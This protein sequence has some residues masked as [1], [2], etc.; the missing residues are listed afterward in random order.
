[1]QKT[2]N[3]VLTV[4][5]IGLGIC[6]VVLWKKLTIAHEQTTSAQ[7]ALE[8]EK[9]VRA[10]HE[11]RAKDLE[12]SNRIL[13]DKVQQFTEVTTG[14]RATE[15]KQSSNLTAM[16]Q[17]MKS[18]PKTGEGGSADAGGFGK[19]M[20]EM[21]EKM[22]KDPS[23]REMV[24]GQQKE[25]IK[26]MYKGLF[27]ELNLTPEEQDKVTSLLTDAQLKNLERAGGVFGDKSEQT[28]QDTRKVAEEAKNQMESELK[29][30]LGDERFAAYQDYQKNLGERMQLDQIKTRLEGANLAL[31][32]DQAVQLLQIMKEEKAAVPP[33][34][35][36]DAG[37]LGQNMK[38]LMTEEN[39]KKQMDWMDDYQKRVM[40]RV[41]SVLTAEQFKEYKEQ[42][43]QQAAM[44]KFG[45]KMAGQMFGSGAKDLKEPQPLQ[46]K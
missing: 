21:L 2:I 32:D 6:S 40:D 38:E 45:L 7:L 12:R 16:A 22:M 10:T 37:Q 29:G 4:A 8:M 18:G 19:G 30:V 11:V 27:K 34:I 35:P 17:L 26:M 1:M 25:T 23:M 5:T 13:S 36:S 28:S 42:A 43:D 14:L 20:G 41:S 31:K 15:A 33:A 44:Q 46:P 39:L 3:I 24:R 9:G